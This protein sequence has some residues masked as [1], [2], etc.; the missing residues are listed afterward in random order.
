MLRRTGVD[1]QGAGYLMGWVSGDR[2]RKG[3]DLGMKFSYF[4]GRGEL[5]LQGT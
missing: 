2:N 1:C 3:L 5:D 4:G